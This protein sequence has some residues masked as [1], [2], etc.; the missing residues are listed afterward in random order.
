MFIVLSNNPKKKKEVMS[1]R[2]RVRERFWGFWKKVLK[3]KIA[4]IKEKERER[5]RGF[6]KFWKVRSFP[7]MHEC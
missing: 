1:T 6:G 2:L 5:G 4:K 7:H 3:K